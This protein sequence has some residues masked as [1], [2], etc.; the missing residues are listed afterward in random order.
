MNYS[1][2]RFY[3][4]PTTLLEEQRQIAAAE[5]AGFEAEV[6]KRYRNT[7]SE[8][9]FGVVYEMILH[10]AENLGADLIVLATHGHTGLAHALM[11]SVTEKVVRY[12][13]C[14]VMTI[15][16]VP[17]PHALKGKHRKSKA[18]RATAG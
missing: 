13:D 12:S 11:G 10:L 17:R 16:T 3:P 9:H 15:R 14:P 7:R 2:P 4:K 6:K 8:I 1:V 18:A 5:M